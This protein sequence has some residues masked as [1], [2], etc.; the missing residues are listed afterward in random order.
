MK[1]VECPSCGGTGI[2]LRHLSG[3][4]N[5]TADV[6]HKCRG[7]GFILI[8]PA[9]FSQSQKPKTDRYASTGGLCMSD[10]CPWQWRYRRPITEYKEF[11]GLAKV[12]NIDYV[13]VG[14]LSVPYSAFYKEHRNHR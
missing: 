3:W 14:C 5:S 13:Y 8:E 1:K 2:I 4:H 7:F 6:C 11:T 9:V 10:F 12:R